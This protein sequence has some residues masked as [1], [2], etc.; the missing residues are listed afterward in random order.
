LET[1]QITH[2]GVLGKERTGRKRL[3]L[4]LGLVSSLVVGACASRER[5]IPDPGRLDPYARSQAAARAISASADDAELRREAARDLGRIGGEEAAATLVA[6][7][8]DPDPAV[9]AEAAFGLAISDAHNAAGRL[10]ANL[11]ADA[12]AEV[13]NAA[14]MGLGNGAGDEHERALVTIARDFDL[15]ASV[16]NALFNHYRWRG[17]PAPKEMPDDVLLKYAEHPEAEGRAG[18]GN[19]CRSVKD[20]RAEAPLI[21][22]LTAD[23]ERE[24]RRAAAMGLARPSSD[25]ENPTEMAGSALRAALTD[26][27]ALVVV[28]AC[29]ALG[30]YEGTEESLLPLLDHADFNARATAVQTLARRKAEAAVERLAAMATDD[31]SVFVRGSAIT[32]LAA[33]DGPRAYE[34]AATV[35]EDDA[36]FVRASA[37]DAQSGSSR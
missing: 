31:P 17:R 33:L 29:R 5:E 37:C 20:A 7:L 34:L 10:V 1:A 18:F 6:M 30:S 4:A 15:A 35:L 16:P 3:I 22:L 21:R 23:P 26:A 27:D 32:A 8:G 13:V 24:V 14:A 36:E 28:A 11:P 12:P 25:Q 9:A 19:L 2:R